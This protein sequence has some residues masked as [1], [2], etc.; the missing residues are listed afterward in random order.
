MERLCRQIS[1]LD[2]VSCYNGTMTPGPEYHEQRFYDLLGKQAPFTDE[3]LAAMRECLQHTNFNMLRN[4]V[5][6]KAELRG[7][8]ELLDSIRKFD[9]ASGQMA[10]VTI[11]LAEK[12]R[13]LTVRIYWLTW[14]MIGVG[15]INAVASGWYPLVWWLKHA[16]RF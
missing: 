15:F 3:D 16:F 6:A 7:S 8:V 13:N 2:D 1:G 14:V 11:D 10:A 4:H 9:K 12:T 5:V